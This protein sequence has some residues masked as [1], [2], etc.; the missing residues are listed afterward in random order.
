[1]PISSSA[2]TGCCHGV[3]YYN[4]GG[5]HGHPTAV[6]QDQFDEWINKKPRPHI[7]IAVTNISQGQTRK[8]LEFQGWNTQEVGHLWI[9]TIDNTSLNIYLTKYRTRLQE[10]RKKKEEERV[11]RYQEIQGNSKFSTGPK[12]FMDKIKEEQIRRLCRLCELSDDYKAECKKAIEDY[13]YI[14]LPNRYYNNS[15]GGLRGF[16]GIRR[17][18]YDLVSVQRDR[19]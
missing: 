1:M 14:T 15:Y 16:A 18:V 11:R 8:Y 10:D 7:I 12:V 3:N 17:L 5:A 9:S 4:L 13:Y 19:I 2:I 6:N